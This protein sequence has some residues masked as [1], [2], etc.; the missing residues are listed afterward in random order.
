[1]GVFLIISAALLIVFAGVGIKLL[2]KKDGEFAG[3]CASKNPMLADDSGV[4]SACGKPAGST[5]AED[6]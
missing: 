1:M 5:C 6:E 3:T 4:C 2:V